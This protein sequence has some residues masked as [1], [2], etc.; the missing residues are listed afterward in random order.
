MSMKVRLLI[1]PFIASLERA[2]ERF[3]TGMNPHMGFQVKIKGESLAAELT[4][5][6]LLASVNQHVPL[7]LGIVKESLAA[8]WVGALE[9]LVAMDR[10]VLLQRGTVVEDLAA[11]LQRASENFWLSLCATSVW[12]TSNLSS[13]PFLEQHGHCWHLLCAYS[14]TLNRL[15]FLDGNLLLH[16]RC[17]VINRPQLLMKLGLHLLIKATITIVFCRQAHPK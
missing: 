5:I 10:V 11:A 14:A 8:T 15:F 2:Y 3:L 7:E 1:K 12:S 17:L 13:G 9:E 16:H 6:W 4:L